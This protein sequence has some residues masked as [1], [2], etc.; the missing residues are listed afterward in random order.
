MST[1]LTLLPEVEL[2]TR[3]RHLPAAS[4]A[5][6]L[7]MDSLHPAA[8]QYIVADSSVGL[9]SIA[10]QLVHHVG[11]LF[12]NFGRPRAQRALEIGLARSNFRECLGNAHEIR[13]IL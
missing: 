13:Q 3:V 7:C 5:D 2:D 6:C 10:T 11:K 9:E 8:S 1:E 4:T 12:V